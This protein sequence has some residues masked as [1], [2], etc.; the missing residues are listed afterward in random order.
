MN[1]RMREAIRADAPG[2]ESSPDRPPDGDAGR[3]QSFPLARAYLNNRDSLLRFLRRRTGCPQAAQ[4]LL[5][6]IWLRLDRVDPSTT[7]ANPAAYLQSIAANL[8]IDWQRRQS[9]R[10]RLS[11]PEQDANELVDA[12]APIEEQLQS[13]QALAFL[14]SLL[15]ELP[16]R[17]R[18]AF[19]LYRVDGLPMKAVAQR[20]G[21]SERTVEHQVA[22]AMVHCRKR[23]ADA[24]LWP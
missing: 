6:E 5:N 2:T 14:M 18:E 20:M 8:A 21:I 16:P 11:A 19:I 7:P 9:V 3:V 13:R 15:D 4:D 24:G 23:L 12:A 10:S 17:R 1:D 22:A